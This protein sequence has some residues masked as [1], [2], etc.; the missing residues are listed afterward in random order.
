GPTPT[1]ARSWRRTC[2]SV[3]KFDPQ[4]RC[5]L[6]RKSIV[7]HEPDA[8]R[9]ADG[10]LDVGLFGRAFPGI[11]M[12]DRHSIPILIA[13]KDPAAAG[14]E[15]EV[16]RHVDVAGDVAARGERAVVADF[17]NGNAVVA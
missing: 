14:V 10:N 7:R 16:P 9:P 13:D 2:R 17:E 5:G 12:E 8:H 11:P 3:W 4:A 1:S 6:V 15:I